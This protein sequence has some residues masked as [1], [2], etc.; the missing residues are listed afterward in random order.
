MHHLFHHH[1]QRI[2][3]P[4]K[5]IKSTIRLGSWLSC[6]EKIDPVVK[7]GAIKA[8]SV[9]PIIFLVATCCNEIKTL[10]GQLWR[11]LA[12]SFICGHRAHTGNLSRVGSRW[13][14][15]FAAHL[16]HLL[17]QPLLA[18]MAKVVLGNVR[19]KYKCIQMP[20]FWALDSIYRLYMSFLVCTAAI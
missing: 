9:L 20:L 11:L 13:N 12:W 7:W 1:L 6:Q 3:R 15:R 2:P 18:V 14:P 10:Y 16:Q 5:S 4:C 17:L 19:Q 8:A